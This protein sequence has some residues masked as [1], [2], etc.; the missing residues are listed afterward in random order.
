MQRGGT[1]ER[2]QKRES[3][4]GLFVLHICLKVIGRGRHMAS[5]ASIQTLGSYDENNILAAVSNLISSFCLLCPWCAHISMSPNVL[6][7]VYSA[8]MAVR[9]CRTPRR[10]EGTQPTLFL[11]RLSNHI[12]FSQGSLNPVDP[13]L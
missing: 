10:E 12:F 1:S 9:I 6:M 2:Q 7:K 3:Y 11:I 8:F 5:K 13:T 4:S